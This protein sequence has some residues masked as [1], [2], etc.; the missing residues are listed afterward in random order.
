M[1]GYVV[2][3][4]RVEG[5]WQVDRLPDGLPANLDTFLG[6]LRQQPTAGG[7]L[8]LVNIADDFF[9]AARTAPGGGVRLLL[10]DVT[11]AVE[12][13]LA[14]Q[15]LERLGEELPDADEPDEVWPAGDLGIFAD[16]GL[17]ERELGTI[18]DDLDLYAD[19]M[20][21]DVARRVGFAEPLEA[22][23]DAVVRHRGWE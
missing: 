13:D 6:A 2:A 7:V 21:L 14:R 15:V 10:S 1:A 12:W 19:E 11:A 17:A 23:V 8:G 9:V 22:A 5:R 18:L 4:L 20:L 3:V 16:L